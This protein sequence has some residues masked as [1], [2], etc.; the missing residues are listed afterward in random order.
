MISKGKTIQ[1]KILGGGG[2]GK[3]MHKD[4]ISWGTVKGYNKS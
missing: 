2:G 4:T 1:E 3:R